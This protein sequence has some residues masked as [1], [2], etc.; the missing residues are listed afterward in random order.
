ME[1]TNATVA[2]IAAELIATQQERDDQF[3]AWLN[4]SPTGGPN[5]DGLYPLP[6]PSGTVMVPCWAAITDPITGSEASAAASASAASGS[7][8][9]ALASHDAIVLIK[10]AIDLL[11]TEAR[12]LRDEAQARAND[13]AAEHAAAASIKTACEAIQTNVQALHDD[14]ANS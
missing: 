10:A 14:W 6:S 11:L 12:S 1:P 13:A 8:G 4:G 2:S 5:S 7:A 9:E 3:V